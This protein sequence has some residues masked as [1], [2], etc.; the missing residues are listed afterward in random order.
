MNSSQATQAKTNHEE[1]NWIDA[2]NLDMVEPTDLGKSTKEDHLQY[3]PNISIKAWQDHEVPREDLS[4]A[5]KQNRSIQRSIQT[6]E[7]PSD[8][9]PTLRTIERLVSCTYQHGNSRDGIFGHGRKSQDS[10]LARRAL[11]EPRRLT[12]RSCVRL[13]FDNG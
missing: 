3:R 1:H 7:Q 13:I 4:A 8:D 9:Q 12:P 5:H 6:T 2:T 11:T 10:E